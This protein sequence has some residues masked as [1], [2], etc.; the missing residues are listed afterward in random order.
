[1]VPINR[2]S[3]SVYVLSLIA[4]MVLRIF[5]LP[6]AVQAFNPDWILL[7]LIYWSLAAPEKVGIFNA[8]FVGLLAD[9]LTGKLLGQQALAY[10]VA[11]YLCVKLHKR[12]R[13]FP[14]LQQSL[15]IMGVLLVA[16]SLLFWIENLARPPRLEAVFW[17]PVASG[18]L[19]WPLVFAIMRKIRLPE[20][21]A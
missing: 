3:L 18:T 19:A 4:A 15:F 11:I 1:M 21:P 6:S 10:A 8:C 20:L 14:L 13:R 16:Q 5:P 7:L 17:L 2:Q 9:V 12:L